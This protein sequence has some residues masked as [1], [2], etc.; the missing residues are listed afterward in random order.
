MKKILII[1]DEEKLRSLMARIIGLEGFEVIEAGDCKSGLKKIEQHA[2]DV[3]LC[4]VKLPDGNGVDLTI[5]IKEKS[6]QT[7]VILLTAYGNIP[8]GV[9][10]I[11]N[12]AFDYIVKGN[13]NNKII[14]LLHRAIEKGNLTKRI[15]QLEAKLEDKL[16]FDGI[17]GDSKPL[18]QSINLAKKVAPTDT[19]VLLTGETGTGKEVFAAAI[20]QSSPRK[21]QNFVAIN[22]SAFSHDLLESEMF[23]HIAG[24]F[25]GATKDK[26]GLFE[27]ANGGTIFLD[28]VGEMALDLQAKLLRVIENGE[29][30]KVGE[31]KPTKVDVR[32]IAA[33]NR[34]LPKEIESGHFRQ[35]LFYRLSV[36]Q[37]QL[38]ALRERVTD[39]E[40][41]AKH[42]LNFFSLKTNKKIKA[43]SDEFVQLLKLHTWPGNIRELKNV[44]ERSVILETEAIL[45]TDC[46]PME[47]Q[48]LKTANTSGESPLLSAFSLA[49]AEKIHI[50]KVLNY[51]NHNKT[52]T[53]KLLNIAL[54]TLYRK[55]EEYKIN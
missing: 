54:T 17:I 34:D 26:K 53:A 24:S 41:L 15:A 46:L 35:D 22:C 3:V 4:D 36:F 11:K 49:S 28:E 39:I 55:L 12:G 47:I 7:E 18:L 42:F 37:I 48:Q 19:T 6:P 51:T 30:L 1:D 9:Q 27:E 14:P 16:S 50:Q 5:A 20:H 25:T 45:T 2:F 23:G 8:D 44:L 10:A 32:I 43:L 33:T 40:P 29:F 13:D 31:N 52:E 38:P 21:H